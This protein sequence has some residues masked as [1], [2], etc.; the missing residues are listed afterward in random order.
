MHTHPI[1]GQINIVL[2]DVFIT[3]KTAAAV[4]ILAGIGTGSTIM[5]GAVAAKAIQRKLTGTP[6]HSFLSGVAKG[7]SASAKVK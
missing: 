3:G 6:V 5:A 7:V 2:K 4:M 1:P